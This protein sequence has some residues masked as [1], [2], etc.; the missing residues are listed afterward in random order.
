MNKEKLEIQII[1]LDIG[2]GYVKGYTEYNGAAKECLFKSVVSLGRDIDFDKFED[3]IYLEVNKENY[4]A[5]ILAEKEGDSPIQNLRDDKTT[6]TVKKLIFAA[7]N[8]IAISET[9]KLMIGV[10]KKLFTKSELA[11]IQSAYK[12]LEVE[13]KDRITG[14]Y[15]KITIADVSVF[16]EADAALIWH[17][18]D[19]VNFEKMMCMVTIGFRTTEISCYD[20]NMNFIDKLSKTNELGNKTALDYVQRTLESDRIMKSLNEIDTSD[21][22]NE[23]KEIGYRN[24]SEKIEQDIEGMLVNLQ[25][26]EVFIGGG[27]ALKLHFNEYKV[28]ADAQMITAKGLYKIATNTFK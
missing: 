25:E 14:A 19:K 2:R 7:L 27:T 13:I 23:L 4:F 1:G 15:K 8:K 28:V 18:R 9:V 22:Y 20:R 24:L 21:D 6:P 5:G 17:V 3:P 12:G 10:P 11:K 16:R 26:S